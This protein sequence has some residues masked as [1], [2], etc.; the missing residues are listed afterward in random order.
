MERKI[1]SLSDLDVFVQELVGKITPK[2]I[3]LL[4]GPLAAGKTE[5]VK[6]I[7]Q[8]YRT[9]EVASPTFAIH[10]EYHSAGGKVM[11]HID[12]YRLE[13]EDDLEST[14]LWDLFSQPQGLVVIEWADRLKE[15]FLPP[16]WQKI[17]IRIE[18][19]PDNSR[20]IFLN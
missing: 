10:H 16:G 6:R 13:N 2:C 3:L 11:D 4:S 18:K 12:L 20:T 19:N 8:H 14:G 15:E 9:F 1:H 17:F 5:L 7:C